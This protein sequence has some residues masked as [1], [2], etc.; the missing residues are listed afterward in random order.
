MESIDGF[1]GAAVLAL[2]ATIPGALDYFA[3]RHEQRRA[4]AAERRAAAKESDDLALDAWRSLVEPLTLEVD[5]LRDLLERQNEK[6][7]RQS[8]DLVRLRFGAR[9]LIDQLLRLDIEPCWLDDPIPSNS[10]REGEER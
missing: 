5:K 4:R 3:K 1:V 6:M 8:A 10:R 7:Q 9:A 2:I